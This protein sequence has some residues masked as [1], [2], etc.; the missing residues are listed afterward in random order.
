M[1]FTSTCVV[2]VQTAATP[3]FWLSNYSSTKLRSRERRVAGIWRP[4]KRWPF[5]L[6]HEIFSPSR[7]RL[8]AWI[9]VCCISM[10]LLSCI[11]CDL[12]TGLSSAQEVLRTFCCINNFQINSEMETGQ[13]AQFNK[14]SG[15][16]EESTNIFYLFL[17][18][19]NFCSQQKIFNY[20]LTC[21]PITRQRLSKHIPATHSHATIGYPLVGNGPVNT[22]P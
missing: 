4:S 22:H 5:G 9:I 20:T 17:L 1:I 21:T 7:I 2:Q 6:G 11:V 10:F 12:A 14:G 15:R 13:R 16:W 3:A 19:N 8:G 18:F